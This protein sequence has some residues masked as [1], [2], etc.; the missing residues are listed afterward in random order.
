VP[1]RK[2]IKTIDYCL[3]NGYIFTYQFGKIIYARNVK[4]FWQTGQKNLGELKKCRFGI[5]DMLINLV[6]ES[7]CS[8]SDNEVVTRLIDGLKRLDVLPG[9]EIQ[10]RISFIKYHA[11]YFL[12]KS[13]LSEEFHYKEERYRIIGIERRNWKYPIIARQVSSGRLYK[14]TTECVLRE[15]GAKTRNLAIQARRI[16]LKRVRKW[17]IDGTNIS[18]KEIVKNIFEEIK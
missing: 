10:L 9:D 11:N 14:F 12:T 2:E 5:M 3:L 1:A 8:T 17:N 7:I 13:N 16:E 18:P 15:I 6:I 4:S